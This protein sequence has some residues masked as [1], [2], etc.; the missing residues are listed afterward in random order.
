MTLPYCRRPARSEAQR[1]KRDTA[2][3]KKIWRGAFKKV[4]QEIMINLNCDELGQTLA[5]GIHC[6]RGRQICQQLR[7]GDGLR[8]LERHRE[9]PARVT[10]IGERVLVFSEQLIGEAVEV[11][12]EGLPG[13]FAIGG[14][15]AIIDEDFHILTIEA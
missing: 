11:R 6:T 3:I 10:A 4:R 8:S 14:G 15:Q 5:E 12:F 13:F 9:Q 2:V 7:H 1:Y